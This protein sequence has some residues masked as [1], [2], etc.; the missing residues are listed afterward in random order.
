[1][2]RVGP[3]AAWSP[4]FRLALAFE[5]TVSATAARMRS[6]KAA[7]LVCTSSRRT[8]PSASRSA[9][10]T[11]ALRRRCVAVV[12]IPALPKA[13]LSASNSLSEPQL[14]RRQRFTLQTLRT[15]PTACTG[16]T[17]ASAS[18]SE[19]NNQLDDNQ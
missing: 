12:Q 2:K 10:L 3:L 4:G 13:I 17:S 1:M 9:S 19:V 18:L 16:A 15:A 5:V 8:R 14:R 6:F 7:F 11:T